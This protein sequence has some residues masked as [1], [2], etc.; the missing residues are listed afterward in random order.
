M[1]VP[2]GQKQPAKGHQANEQ[3]SKRPE[4]KGRRLFG[5]NRVPFKKPDPDAVPIL[6][7]GP[8]NNFMRFKEALSKKA[9]E[10]YGRLGKLINMGKFD[11]LEEPDRTFMDLSDEFE[12]ADYLD[13]MKTYRK[14]KLDREEK[15]PQLYA[16]TLRYLCEE[17]LEAVQKHQNWADIEANA[18]PVCLWKIVEDKHRVHS[19]SEVAAIVKLEA[20]NQL[21]NL[22]QGAFKSI[23]T[24]KKMYNGALKANHDHGNPTKD[25][26]EQAMDFFDG[27]DNGR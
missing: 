4:G 6:K 12:M 26:S 5:R 2:K 3:K 7:F 22:K 9:L 18:D 16:L 21:K 23:I 1:A 24:C 25:K 27:L 14:L 10:K 15:E 8:G 17:S 13:A 19:T 11:N 20:R